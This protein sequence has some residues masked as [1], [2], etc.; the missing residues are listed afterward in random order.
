MV[1]DYFIKPLQDSKFVEFRNIMMG[2]DYVDYINQEFFGCGDLRLF[3]SYL[4]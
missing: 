4:N 1:G 2:A 3:T